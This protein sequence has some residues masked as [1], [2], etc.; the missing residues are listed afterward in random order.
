[1]R[2]LAFM[3]L[4][5]GLLHTYGGHALAQGALGGAEGGGGVGAGTGSEGGGA[6]SGDLNAVINPNNVKPKTLD[7]A[8]QR[9]LANNP[10][11][12]LAEANLRQAQA[13][14]EQAKLKVT[15][16]VMIAM[17]K[18]EVD[19]LELE[20]LQ[21]LRK[22]GV[23][24]EEDAR[25]ARFESRKS[26]LELDYLLG[27]GPLPVQSMLDP[28]SGQSGMPWG[29]IN[30]FHSAAL[31]DGLRT[32]I[33]DGGG[34]T[35]PGAQESQGGGG[36]AAAEAPGDRVRAALGAQN[37]N[38]SLNA[39]PLPDLAKVL[40]DAIGV[41]VIFDAKEF[42]GTKPEETRITLEIRDEELTWN[43][44]IQAISDTHNVGFLI[45]DYGILITTPA[46]A[47]ARQVGG[48][49]GGGTGGAAG[50]SGGGFF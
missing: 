20:R 17:E 22:Q 30:N 45:R 47:D 4:F 21:T 19:R 3:L 25:G 33:P 15:N 39:I 18:A 35:T 38:V 10:D 49:L 32:V 1:M 31:G 8:I 37:A 48:G 42:S 24:S 2:K 50:G 43:D 44:I 16:Q 13:A 46:K 34:G 29:G 5:A 26:D 12:R 7:E 14:Y 11:I 23:I 36:A 40:S 9:A 6:G 27:V 41:P 28:R